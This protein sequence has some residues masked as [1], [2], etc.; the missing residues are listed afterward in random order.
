[1]VLT[2][3]KAMSLND[4]S[5]RSNTIAMTFP[6]RYRKGFL[7]VSMYKELGIGTVSSA[8]CRNTTNIIRSIMKRGG[9]AECRKK[10]VYS[11]RNL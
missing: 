7:Y 10:D 8:A 9:T 2:C 4:K 3:G 5:E 6:Q 1:M 11:L